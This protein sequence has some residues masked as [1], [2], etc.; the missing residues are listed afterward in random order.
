M[1]ESAGY[2][3]WRAAPDLARH[4]VCTWAGRFGAA[5]EQY[6]DRVLPDGCIDI[7]WT[8]AGVVVAGP[9]TRCVPLAWRPG[10][11]FAGVRF[12]A[13]CSAVRSRT[14]EGASDSY[15]TAAGRVR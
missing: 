2:R 7:V 6:T 14:L 8:G 9:D 3:E 15:K 13:A 1:T 4:V 11:R 12:R 5:G 10:A